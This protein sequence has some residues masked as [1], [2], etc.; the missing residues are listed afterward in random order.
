MNDGIGLA[1]VSLVRYR[2]V[3]TK[4]NQGL[5]GS[6]TVLRW[7][8]MSWNLNPAKILLFIGETRGTSCLQD[9]TL[10]AGV[11]LLL[12]SGERIISSKPIP[13]VILTFCW[14]PLS[15]FKLIIQQKP[16]F[17]CKCIQSLI[18]S[19]RSMANDF[20]VGMRVFH[21]EKTI[22]ELW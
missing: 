15:W 19:M 14:I 7:P 2:Q 9:Y 17:I 21:V 1:S 22:V 12:I 16:C 5:R 13:S 8:A 20:L 18:A 11:C 3:R 10:G 4:A 6:Y